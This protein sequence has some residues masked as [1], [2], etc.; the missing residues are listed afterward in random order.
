MSAPSPHRVVRSVSRK[1]RGVPPEKP[2]DWERRLDRL[3]ARADQFLPLF[4]DGPP[5]PPTERGLR[6]KRVTDLVPPVAG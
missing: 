2:A 6:G 1:R 3:A 4:E 5:A